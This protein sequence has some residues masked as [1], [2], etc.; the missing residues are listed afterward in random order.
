MRP[1]EL[2][3]FEALLKGMTVQIGEH[4][5]CF[6]AEH[7]LCTV[8]KKQIP[9]GEAEVMLKTD[10]SLQVFVKLCQEQMT[11]DQLMY[12]CYDLGFA[13]FRSTAT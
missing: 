7:E 5:Y 10:C 3:A 13:K 11:D 9:G 12:I 6:D 8:G 4:S 2:V 1:K